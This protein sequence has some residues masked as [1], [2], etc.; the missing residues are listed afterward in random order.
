MSGIR[1]VRLAA[2]TM[3]PLALLS[4][5]AGIGSKAIERDRDSFIEALTRSSKNQI[6][7]NLLHLRY[8]E[9]PTFID[10][11]QIVS[12]YTLETSGGVAFRPDSLPSS[13]VIEG[14]VKF[15]ERP[16][17]TYRP[18][19]GRAFLR[20]LLLPVPPSTVFSS[21]QAGWPPELVLSNAVQ[22]INGVA[23][24]RATRLS[25]RPGDRKFDEM[26]ELM[27]A[28]VDSGV[29]EF[30]V[31]RPVEERKKI[32]K[33][34]PL[35]WIEGTAG[36]TASQKR[37]V[38]RLREILGLPEG[39]YEFELIF[40][41]RP[42][43]PNQIA[44]RP[45]SIIQMLANVAATIPVPEQHI[46]DGRALPTIPK[47]DR[48]LAA[49]L[50]VKSGSQKPED[51]FVFAHYEKTWFWVENT[52]FTSKRTFSFL[53]LIYALANRDKDP[54]VPLITIPVG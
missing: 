18:L 17:L 1:I 52:D 26:V 28:L 31:G 24:A 25:R 37:Q 50:D 5:C 9:P 47:G 14:G 4:A 15:Q 51:A 44:V 8:A 22:E 48:K 41:R 2:A 34:R 19:D 21:I 35:L 53:M 7:I 32:D 16:T 46:R 30:Q 40:G 3:L 36:A 13:A 43:N 38:A 12:G 33:I 42:R 23:N 54:N 10:L 39:M 6:F 27:T 29:L 20:N 45:R 11:T 49:Y